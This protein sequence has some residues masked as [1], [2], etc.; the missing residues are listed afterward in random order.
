MAIIIDDFVAKLYLWKNDCALGYMC[1]QFLD[2]LI[3][4]VSKYFETPEATSILKIW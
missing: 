1:I 3:S 2:F 4:K